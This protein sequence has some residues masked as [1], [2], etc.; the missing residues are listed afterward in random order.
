MQILLQ[1]DKLWHSGSE[2][3]TGLW[4]DA[5][6]R[7]SCTLPYFLFNVLAFM[8]VFC[9]FRRVWVD[10][11]VNLWMPINCCKLNLMLFKPYLQNAMHVIS[12]CSY[13]FYTNLDGMLFQRSDDVMLNLNKL[14][15][16]KTFRNRDKYHSNVSFK[17]NISSHFF[18]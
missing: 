12:T 13:P 2:N 14:Y 7:I 16:F 4:F 10:G 11:A 18:G 9:P 1:T 6:C 8:R 3:Y 17:K 15:R 5:C